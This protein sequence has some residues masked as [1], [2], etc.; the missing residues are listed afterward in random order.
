MIRC[1]QAVVQFAIEVGFLM[2]IQVEIKMLHYTLQVVFVL[3]QLKHYILVICR[4]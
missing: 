3:M 2:L 1:D 4:Y